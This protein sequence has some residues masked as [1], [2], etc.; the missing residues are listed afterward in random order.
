MSGHRSV[1]KTL[2]PKGS[3]SVRLKYPDQ[4][5]SLIMQR[6]ID[7]GI[8][9]GRLLAGGACHNYDSGYYGKYIRL[10]NDEACM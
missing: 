4:L 10:G 1:L 6:S 9:F 5:L 3:L 8:F 7:P 2:T